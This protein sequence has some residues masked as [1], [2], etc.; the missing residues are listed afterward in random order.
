MEA[1]KPAWV[2]LSSTDPAAARAFYAKVFDWRVEVNPD[3]QYGG[4]AL[5]KQGDV[6]V[7][8]IGPKQPGDA[9]PSAWS[10]YIGTTDADATAK[11]V[12]TAGGKVVA[13]PFDVP[14]QGRM[15]V[16]QDPSGAFLS[17]WQAKAMQGF[18]AGGVNQFGWAELT[19]RGLDKDLPFYA[20]VFG[21]TAKKSTAG[22]TDTPPYTEFQIGGESI[23]GAM[24]TP[25]TMPKEMPSYWMPYFNVADVDAA[26]KQ[27]KDAGAHE[28]VAPQD[29]PGGR[30][31]I[32][33]DPAG[34]SFGLATFKQR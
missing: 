29:F 15:T 30:F 5:A 17:G 1:N 20:S 22:G 7:A 12:T 19:A 14:G 25:A 33:S 23:A 6:D 21:W 4:Y 11:K 26:F 28:M 27:A 8:G 34:A 10:I 13:P 31:A 9:T 24:E 3:P 32:V 2:D 16:F 18:K